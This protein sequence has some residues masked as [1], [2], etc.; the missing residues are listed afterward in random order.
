MMAGIGPF[1]IPAAR[2]RVAVHANDLNPRCADYLR[3]NAALNKVEARLRVYNLASPLQHSCFVPVSLYGLRPRMP[4]RLCALS[5]APQ[6]LAFLSP[7][8]ALTTSS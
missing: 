4:A 3:L 5:L 2:R 6:C 8:A 7:H 1:A